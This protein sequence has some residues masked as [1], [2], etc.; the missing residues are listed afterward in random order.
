MRANL[1]VFCLGYL[2]VVAVATGY[3]LPLRFM[4]NSTSF[5]SFKN[6]TARKFFFRGRT[7]ACAGEYNAARR[8]FDK[9]IS[10]EQNYLAYLERGKCQLNS[11][12]YKGAVEDLNQALKMDTKSD[13]A[14][15]YR[16]MARQALGDNEGSKSD[17]EM[18]KKLNPK[19]APNYSSLSCSPIW[20]EM[21]EH[22]EESS[23]AISID[24][25]FALHY[26][27]RGFAREILGDR[28]GALKDYTVAISLN[29]K[30]EESYSNRAHLWTD[31][32]KSID[33]YTAAIQLDPTDDAAFRGRSYMRIAIGAK[34][35]ALSDAE[36]SIGLDPKESFNFNARGFA[37]YALGDRK[38][39]LDDF[40]K[41]IW[42]EPIAHNY[43]NRGIIRAKFGDL[44]G[45]INDFTYASRIERSSGSY[46]SRA[47]ARFLQGD[48]SAAIADAWHAILIEPSSAL[49]EVQNI[50]KFL[51]ADP[52]SSTFP[53]PSF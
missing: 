23:E 17:A 40:D 28:Q 49:H 31:R 37:R 30:D 25:E 52:K 20:G 53:Y 11:Q 51:T 45:A 13:L 8:E 15:E 39:A 21:K 35:G 16:S 7:E 3:V 1:I 36:E 4:G 10:L 32:K 50:F 29:P 18:A 42:L 5:S 38:G 6:D 2:L 26:R 9:V 27:V 24:P 34:L 12:N 33:D 43:E 44:E 47:D 41:A 19:P 46:S 48:R 14:Y 22:L